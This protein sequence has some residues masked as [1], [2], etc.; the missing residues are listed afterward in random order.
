MS[1]SRSSATTIGFT[2]SI[3]S[4]FHGINRKFIILTIYYILVYI[5]FYKKQ[6]GMYY[7]LYFP[8][9]ASIILKVT[10]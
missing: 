5:I 8:V 9:P 10:F 2:N 4:F 3:E 7:L 6:E 1:A